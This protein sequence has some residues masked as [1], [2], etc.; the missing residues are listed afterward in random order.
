M[1]LTNRL[2][3]QVDQPVWEWMRFQPVTNAETHNMYYSPVTGSRYIYWNMAQA[4]YRYDTFTDG[5][6]LFGNAL[7]TSPATTLGGTWK[8]ED[9]HYTMPLSS[10]GTT[11]FGAFLTGETALGYDIK[12]LAGQGAGQTR[13]ITNVTDPITMDQFVVTAYNNSITTTSYITDSSK[14]WIPNQWRN[15]QVRIYLGT[16]QQFI[17]RDILYNNND[18]LYFANTEWHSIDPHRAYN[19]IWDATA[20]TPTAA[21]TRGVIEYNSITV[22]SPWTTPLNETSKLLIKCGAIHSAQLVSTNAFF[23]HYWYDPLQGNWLAKHSQIGVMPSYTVSTEIGFE[24]MDTTL[25]PPYD[26]GSLTSITGSRTITD[27]TKAWIPNQWANSKIRDKVSGQEGTIIT[28]TPISLTIGSDFDV[29]SSASNAYDIVVDDDRIYMNGGSHASMGQFSLRTNSWHPS[30]RYEDGVANVAH[31]RL[32]GSLEQMHPISTI[33]RTGQVATVTT[34]TGNPFRTG[35]PVFISGSVGA[36]S[37]FYNGTF[38]VTSSYPLSAALT[39]TTQPTQFT[40]WMSGTPA[41]NATLQ[42]NTTGPIYDMSKNWV[43]NEWTGDI[44]QIWSSN[45]TAPTTQY[46]IITGNTSQSLTLGSALGSSIAGAVWGYSIISSASFGASFGLGTASFN[47]ASGSTVSGAPFIYVSASLSA[48]VFAIP[49]GSPITGSGATIP[50]N[51]FY[52]SYEIHPNSPNFISMSLSAN[53]TATTTN[54]PFTASLPLTYGHGQAT[55]GTTTTL[56]DSTRTWPTNF[57]VGARVRFLAGTGAGVESAISSNT[58]TV[59]T[60]GTTTAPDTTTVYSII[61]NT[62]RGAGAGMKWVWNIGASGSAANR[63]KYLYCF[64][65]GSTMRVTKYNINTMQYEYPRITPFSTQVGENLTTGTW[66]AFD[67]DN[68]IY[69][70]PNVTSRIYYIDTDLD[71]SEVGPTMPYGHTAARAGSNRVAIV[72]TADNLKYLYMPRQGATEFWRCL[73]FT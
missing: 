56:T 24:A 35:D 10:S 72:R 71:T 69:V 28:N 65:G 29:L 15:Y 30:Q 9:G 67:G 14:K 5:F 48:S 70:Q 63:G 18:T 23:L 42:A 57:W 19:H 11:V 17:V 61:P 55:A 68:R 16:A 2:R 32:S 25:V 46:R 49:L 64:E 41:G 27:A 20:L 53:A 8:H 40:Y 13:R 37:A 39:S 7:P 3:P 31:V 62:A 1:P 36:D 58:A 12:V 4:V 50:A 34:I 38:I 6:G 47:I 73:L 59:L 52:R 45:A 21:A 22:D 51:T 66:Y 26:S 43:A 60:F 54:A 44:L 33:T